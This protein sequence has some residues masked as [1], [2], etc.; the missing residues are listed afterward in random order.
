MSYPYAGETPMRGDEAA[1][2]A[3]QAVDAQKRFVLCFTAA[4]GRATALAAS[5]SRVT[6]RWRRSRRG[7]RTPSRCGHGPLPGIGEQRP[8]TASLRGPAM[9]ELHA[10]TFYP[11]SSQRLH[12]RRLPARL[13]EKGV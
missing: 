3:V 8:R 9:P 4:K 7:N 10:Q 11:S 1:R 12:D 6:I 5:A 2:N 13:S